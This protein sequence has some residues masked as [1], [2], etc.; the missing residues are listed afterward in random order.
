MLNSKLRFI[1]NDKDIN[2]SLPVGMTLLDFL[3]K[4]QRLTGTKEG[5]REGDCGACT[6]LIGKLNGEGVNYHSVN[7]CL[8]PV[9]DVNGK[10]IVTVEGFDVGNLNAVQEFM[11]EE[12]GTQCGFCTPGFI[13]SILGYFLSNPSPNLSKAIN[14]VDGNI[15]RCTGYAGIRRA[16]S[17]STQFFTSNYNK[18]LSFLE[19][20]V[21]LK[22]IPEYFLSLPERLRELNS[23]LKKENG[24]SEEEAKFI[25]SG[26]T[27]LF[28]KN[29]EE[30]LNSNVQLISSRSILNEISETHNE[31]IIGAGAGISQIQNSEIIR[32][33]FPDLDSQ[34]NLFGSLPIR[35]RATAAGNIINASPI[36]DL[37]NILLALGAT[38]TVK[39]NGIE[40][41]IL[42]KDFYLGYKQL[43]LS[44]NELLIKIKIKKPKGNYYFNFEKVSRRTYLDIASVNS[45][46]YLELENEIITNCNISAGGVA[47]IPLLLKKSSGFLIGKEISIDNLESAASIADKEISPI[48]DARGS[49]KY[50]RL[51]LRQLIFAHFYKLFPD[52]INLEELI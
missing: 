24:K 6:V 36:A 51:L 38:L 47:P 37:T 25:I 5:C 20:L 9:G 17:K 8:F 40:R 49:D 12:G 19:N 4:H 11:V 26:G 1:L 52:K 2:V 41:E 3:R 39:K 15:C 23:N 35:N 10:H 21:A 42:L 34:L 45:S 28:V 48:S 16:V 18:K 31:I 46:V 7:S 44:A 13:V 43:N 50:K 27:D 29:W 14:S 33:Y 32:K 22:F 30:I